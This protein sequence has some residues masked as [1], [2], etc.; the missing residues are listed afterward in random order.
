MQVFSAKRLTILVLSVLLTGT[1]KAQSFYTHPLHPQVKTLQVMGNQDFQKLP[2]L[3]FDGVSSVTA[4]FDFL[5]D[6]Q[7]W[8]DY[9]IVH[10]DAEWKPDDL[11]AMD[12]LSESFLPR[13][14][15]GITP[16][17][18]TTSE[19]YYHCQV[20]IPNEEVRPT[21]SGN[22]AILFHQQDEPD[23]ILAV[24][25]FMVSAQEAFVSGTI[26]GNTD[27]DFNATHQQLT[28]EIGWSNKKHPHLEPA[29]DLHVLVQQNR[30]LDQSRWIEAPSRIEIGKAYYEHLQS[31]IFEGGNHWRRFEV[32]D[33]HYPGLGVDRI[34]YHAPYYYAYLFEGRARALDNYRYDQDQHGRFLV[35]AKGVEDV[36]IEAEYVKT[37]FTLDAPQQL[38]KQ[39]IYLLGDMTCQMLDDQARME[40]DAEKGLYR[41]ELLLKQGAYNYMYVVPNREV[42][43]GDNPFGTKVST[44]VTEGSHYETPNEYQV[45]VYY[46]PFASRYDHLI[47]VAVLK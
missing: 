34:R 40:Y 5:A 11:D 35:L 21:I 16:S 39:G 38:D 44:S 25:T 27:I 10:C 31:L 14:V 47:G 37:V 30:R 13:H 45:F 20:T 32:T 43:A 3:N 2:V 33:V 46:R 41:K 7:P 26:S 23:S 29:T 24:A 19:S 18:N 9:T 12:F 1:L 6:E 28:M 8:I 15:E 22:Y 36:N 4:S 42:K 17:F